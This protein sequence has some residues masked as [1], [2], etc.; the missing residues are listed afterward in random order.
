MRG[1]AEV[2][3]WFIGSADEEHDDEI[4]AACARTA[5]RVCQQLRRL[6]PFFFFL[7]FL[8]NS[9]ETGAFCA[10]MSVKVAAE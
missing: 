6:A 1:Q 4:S 10:A 7:F 2:E 3:D 8:S 5:P 9:V